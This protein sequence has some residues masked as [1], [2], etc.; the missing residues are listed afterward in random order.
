MS[1]KNSVPAFVKMIE[2]TSCHRVITQ[3][4]FAPL[5]DSMTD[6][7]TEKRHDLVVE[8]LPTIHDVFPGIF[9]FGEASPVEP[10]PGPAIMHAAEDIVLYLHS[11][12]STGF[13]KP[14]P[15]RQHFVLEFAK[16]STPLSFAL[17]ALTFTKHQFRHP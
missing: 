4:I 8:E 7:L 15:W 1:P 9:E 14:I 5:V 2:G 10:F 16:S 17:Y 13:P 6:L 11:S 3:P 12:G